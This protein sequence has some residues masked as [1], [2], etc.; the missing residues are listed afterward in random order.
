MRRI[1]KIYEKYKQIRKATNMCNAIVGVLALIIDGITHHKTDLYFMH[2]ERSLYRMLSKDICAFKNRKK[3]NNKHVEKKTFYGKIPIWICWL[4]GEEEM[5]ELVRLCY[6]RLIKMSPSNAKVVLITSGNVKNYINLKDEI[7]EKYRKG[8]LS[9]TNL[10]DYIRVKLL[11]VYG[12]M[13]IDS[14]VY[15]STH[16]SSD[17]LKRTFYS[18]K[19]CDEFYV[20]HYATKSKWSSWFLISSANSLLFKFCEEMM[21]IYYLKSPGIIDYYIIDYFILIAYH[22]FDEIRYLIDNVELNNIYAFELV[23]I[24]NEPFDQIKMENVLTRNQ[25]NKLSH[26]KQTIL[27]NDGKPTNYAMMLNM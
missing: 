27:V 6:A 17:L 21:E 26:K 25:F 10:A 1:S 5:P 19:T 8:E 12:G 2:I 24:L 15:V 23:K 11:S 22:N 3:Y 16:I 9:Q 14:T 4:Q 13:W 18:Q 20:S 7:V